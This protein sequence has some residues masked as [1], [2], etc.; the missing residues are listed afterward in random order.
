MSL[1]F[2]FRI[3]ELLPLAR[4]F[5]A[6]YV[7]DH[8]AF[9]D[10]LPEDYKPKFLAEYDAAVQ[11]VEKATRSSV[12]V[13]E[14]QIIT[15]RIAAQL[16]SLPQ[17]LNR[18]EARLRRAENLTVSAKKFGIEPV[19]RDRNN[20]EH[21]GLTESLR[22]LL[23]NIDANEAAL[24]AKGQTRSEIDFMQG[25]YDDLV[26]D[27]TAQ[28]SSLSDQR[29]L[30]AANVQL[31]RALYKPMKQLMD[32]GKSLYKGSDKTKLKDYTLRNVRQQV[33]QEQGGGDDVAKGTKAA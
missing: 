17:L 21:E 32:D 11:N 12:A 27:N 19:R 29:L 7:R 30:M 22:T 4:L 24:L 16:E 28:G 10:L 15:A 6:S 25:I 26:A 1:P 33:R 18:L 9:A 8:A 13:A 2:N 20:D 14:R 31:F 23:Q 3:S 5:R